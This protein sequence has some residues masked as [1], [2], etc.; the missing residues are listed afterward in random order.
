MAKR[1]LTDKT[2]Q[3][4]TFSSPTTKGGKPRTQEDFFDDPASGGFPGL[5]LRLSYGG[6]KNWRA[7]YYLNGK[8]RTYALGKYPVMG[9]AAARKAAREFLADQNSFLAK[10]K[11]QETFADVVVDYLESDIRARKVITAKV[12]EQRINKHLLPYFRDLP[13]VAIRRDKIAKRIDA[14]KAKHGASMAGGVRQIMQTMCGWYMDERAEDYQSPFPARYH[15]RRRKELYASKPRE[16]VLDTDDELRAF[17]QATGELGTYGDILRVLLLTGARRTKVATMRWEDI[18]DEG[19]WRLP[20]DDREKFN[21]GAIR[22]PAVVLEIINRQPRFKNCPY[23]FPGKRG[24]TPF[25]EWGQY[26]KLLLAAERRYMPSMEPHTTHDLRRSFA[27]RAGAIGIP[28]DIGELCLGHL[29]GSKVERTYRKNR[30]EAEIQAA[31]QTVADH[32]MAVVGRPPPN[33]VVRLGA[34]N[35]KSSVA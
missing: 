19:L 26:S 34:R 22:L 5:I 27:T 1:K 15:G 32:I 6:T 35:H 28:R 24:R 7:M 4:L 2:I 11:K 33:N 25:N 21:V 18:D 10:P 9:L 17:W 30:P 16:R 29:L 8:S 31:F 20:R 23:V 3:N 13:F 12:I 14:I